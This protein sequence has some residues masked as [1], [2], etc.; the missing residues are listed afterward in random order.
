MRSSQPYRV[1][2]TK[3]A[4]FGMGTAALTVDPVLH[5]EEKS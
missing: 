2:W 5:E 3:N 4:I 1:A